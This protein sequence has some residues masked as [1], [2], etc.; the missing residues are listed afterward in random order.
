MNIKL[1]SIIFSIFLVSCTTETYHVSDFSDV[2]ENVYDEG[3]T[4]VVIL[5]DYTIASYF[6][7]Y[8]H[9]RLINRLADKCKFS[10]CNVL[11]RENIYLKY[12]L[13]IDTLPFVLIVQNGEIQYASSEIDIRKPRKIQSF[14]DSYFKGTL[15][16]FSLPYFN[17][18][19]V[20]LKDVLTAFIKLEYAVNGVD[21]NDAD[22][23]L[24]Q[25][26]EIND[27]ERHFY[28]DYLGYRLGNLIGDIEVLDMYTEKLASY[29]VPDDVYGYLNLCLRRE[30]TKN[31]YP[32]PYFEN[33]IDVGNIKRGEETVIHVPIYNTSATPLILLSAIE[34]C[35]CI[36]AEFPRIIP[37]N[38]VGRVN[39]TYKA[40]KDKGQSENHIQFVTNTEYGD[41]TIRILSN[42]I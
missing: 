8:R 2:I 31:A 18:Q 29:E 13:H 17:A 36:K 22:K 33:E 27:E 11:S 35:S 9:T 40:G 41:E 24:Y 28:A 14:I 30:I 5:G 15:P 39:I 16:I 23:R 34:S 19:G 32:V 12:I 4:N 1:L 10:F 7:T 3:K 37:P 20:D 38:D 26:E 42:V 6:N 25:L 21:V